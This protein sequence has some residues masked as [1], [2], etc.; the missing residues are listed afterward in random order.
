M[1][2]LNNSMW[3][4]APPATGFLDAGVYADDSDGYNTITGGGS[5]S[6]K[7]QTISFWYRNDYANTTGTFMYGGYHGSQDFGGTFVGGDGYVYHATKYNNSFA[8][9][10]KSSSTLSTAQRAVNTWHHFCLRMPNSGTCQIHIDGT[11]MATF[12]AKPNG[13]WPF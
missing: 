3:N 9:N 12:S 1:G 11:E 4:V 5:S 7:R 8:H 6:W 10:A 13:F 2:V